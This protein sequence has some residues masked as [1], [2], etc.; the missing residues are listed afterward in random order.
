MAGL[1]P[2]VKAK[3]ND[4]EVQFIL[5]SGAFYSSLT[6][7]TAA[8][9]N[10]KLAPLGSGIYVQTLGGRFI[11]QV[12]KVTLTLVGVPLPNVEFMVGGRDTG[13]AGLLGQNILLLADVEYDLANGMLRLWRAD[14]C[15]QTMM[16]YWVP[17]GQHYSAMEI[18]RATPAEPHTI[19][20]AFL[21]GKKI[22]VGFD[23]GAPTSLLSLH[24]AARAGLKPGDPGVESTESAGQWIAR[25]ASFKIGDEEIQHA[26]LRM[27]DLG[28][29]ETVTDMLIGADFFLSHRV[30]VASSQHRLY[31]TYNGGPVFNLDAQP[32]SASLGPAAAGEAP[33]PAK[34]GDLPR[35]DGPREASAGQPGSAT[36]EPAPGQTVQSQGAPSSAEPT[37]A[38]GFGRRGAAYAARRDF[39]HA[40]TDLTRACELEPGEPQYFYDRAQ[41]YIGSKEPGLAMADLD[42]VI[43]LKP[44]H[45]PAL[46]ARAQLRLSA[47]EQ[48][49]AVTDLD[50]ADRAAPQQ[51][52]IRLSLG[53][54]YLDAELFAPA[55]GQFDLWLAAHSGQYKGEGLRLRC[56]AGALLGRDLNRALSDCDEALKLRLLPTTA[57]TTL[58]TRALVRLRRGDLDRS[59]S[60]YDHSLKLLPQSP[61]SLY[62]RGLV[63]IKKGKTAEGE[64]DLAAARALQ[65]QIEELFRKDGIIP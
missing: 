8:E 28:A 30:Y 18:Q 52:N 40:I 45:V 4:T 14:D 10:L 23:T 32:A 39:Q 35:S 29:I 2:M 13:N 3:I 12:A 59:L 61:W 1:R 62:G 34:E 41:A 9:L 65:P 31:F 33:R 57:A 5:D 42:Q 16:A 27:A 44:D 60:D 49:S 48:A 7:Q 58:E 54:M 56:R 38:P 25:F 43:K 15:K 51:D 37:D 63:K 17:P 26:R 53:E 47:H 21:N 20:S 64:Q 55:V 11:P 19:G 46:M 22:R 6:P 36:S 24:A 50:A